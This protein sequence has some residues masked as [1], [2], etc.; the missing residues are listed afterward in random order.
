M[1]W[2]GERTHRPAVTFS[3]CAPPGGVGAAGQF[4]GGLDDGDA[5]GI[6]QQAGGDQHAGGAATNDGDIDAGNPADSGVM[7]K[8]Q[9]SGTGIVVADRVAHSRHPRVILATPAGHRRRRR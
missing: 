8:R 4:G 9:G 3:R 7:G 1:P 5:Q 6:G 2:P